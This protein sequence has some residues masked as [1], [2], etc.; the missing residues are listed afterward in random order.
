LADTGPKS[1]G[2]ETGHERAASVTL[3][4][5]HPEGGK[6]SD[7]CVSGPSSW[8]S[9]FPL[10]AM[11]GLGAVSRV[12]ASSGAPSMWPGCGGRTRCG[13]RD[14]PVPVSDGCSRR[15][16]C[17]TSVGSGRRFSS[18]R[19]WMI[20]DLTTVTSRGD[21]AFGQMSGEVIDPL[22]D[23]LMYSPLLLYFA[24]EGAVRLEAGRALPGF[25][26]HG[27]ALPGASFRS[28]PRTCSARQRRFSWS[29]CWP[30]RVS[31]G[32]TAPWGSPDRASAARDLCRA[33]LL[34]RRL[35]GHPN[36]WYANILSLMNLVCGL[37]GIWVILRG[38]PPVYAFGLV[39]L[40][41]FL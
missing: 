37:A 20:T 27:T 2:R 23:K 36:Y 28:R 4:G 19:F 25:R 17:S 30:S 9:S 1:S 22:S 31:S 26:F 21:A 16:P 32:S 3:L 14:Q 33:G 40:G 41:Q 13:E 10:L 6:T 24:L 34:L 18:L 12:T 5:L 15:L 29:S 38:E 11:V 7:G 8:K 35:Q 39:F